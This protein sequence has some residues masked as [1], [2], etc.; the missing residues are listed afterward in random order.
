MDWQL[1]LL[2]SNIVT[3]KLDINF[4]LSSY[5]AIILSPCYCCSVTKWCQILR[6][7]MDFSTPGFPVP[8][9]LRKFAQVYIYWIN[10]AIHLSHPLLPFSPSAFNLSQHQGLFQ[11]VSCLYCISWPKYW[12]F[13]FSISPSN[14]YSGLISIWRRKWQ[15]TP[16]FLP[17][18]SRG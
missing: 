18:E 6:N 12:S 1:M 4:A 14:E 17:G 16:V 13:S 10:E 5:L 8:H 3:M 2:R 7:P 15:P 9:H 11:W